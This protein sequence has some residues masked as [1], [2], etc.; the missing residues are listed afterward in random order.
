MKIKRIEMRV[1]KE[2]H[3][4]VK[5]QVDKEERSISDLIRQLLNEYLDKKNG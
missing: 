2:F 3:S 1:S 4:K 5:K